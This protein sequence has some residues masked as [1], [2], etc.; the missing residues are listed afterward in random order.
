MD[1]LEANHNSSTQVH[2]RADHEFQVS[3]V[4]VGAI[5]V[6]SQMKDPAEAAKALPKLLVDLKAEHASLTRVVADVKAAQ[7]NATSLYKR[8]L[9]EEQPDTTKQ[10][11]V[12]LE[13]ADD[14]NFQ[15]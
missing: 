2:Q 13:H 14:A 4:L 6:V 15:K 11:L 3:E 9:T 5:K 7:A 8:M 10:L 12:N 1:E